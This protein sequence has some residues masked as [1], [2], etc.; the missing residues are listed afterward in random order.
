MADGAGCAATEPS[1]KAVRTLV[2]G[3]GSPILRDDAIGLHIVRALADRLPSD[4]FSV[5]EAGAAGLRL[6]PLLDGWERVVFVDALVWSAE[7]GGEACPGRLHRL[8]LD[9]LRSTLT[10]HSSHEPSLADTLRLGRQAG[11]A[12]PERIL[13]FGVEVSDPFTFDEDM[14]PE[15]TARVEPLADEIADQVGTS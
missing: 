15:L 14:T 8:A 7:L 13:V 6:L 3:L 2:V 11:M 12:L 4:L 9:Q 10:L 5:I 1:T